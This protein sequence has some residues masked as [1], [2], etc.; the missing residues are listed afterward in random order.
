MD[1]Q[2]V[3][4][5]IRRR[6]IMHYKAKF[7]TLLLCSVAFVTAC[8][9][10]TPEQ[11]TA[12]ATATPADPAPINNL[13]SQYL[14]AFNAGDA[15]AVAALYADDATSMPD[16]HPAIDGKAAIQ[17]YLQ[18]MFAQHTAS[19]TIT[20]SD[21]EITGDIAHEHGTFSMTVTPKAGGS[22]MTEN[23]K[24]LVVFKRQADGSWKIHHDVDN[25][26]GPHATTTTQ[27]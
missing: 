2:M 7:L 13:R 23:G 1:H 15:A 24:Y 20:P 16:H 4:A 8:G 22:A 21:T 6:S 26:A 19:I 9:D 18:G 11:T 10:T 25:A 3:Q 27:R 17:D 14:T 5:S 12:P